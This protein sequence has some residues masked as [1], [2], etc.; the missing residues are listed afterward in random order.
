ML[1]RLG[2]IYDRARGRWRRGEEKGE[3]EEDSNPLKRHHR[4]LVIV[5]L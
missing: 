1:E 3:A 4:V 2:P 5:L